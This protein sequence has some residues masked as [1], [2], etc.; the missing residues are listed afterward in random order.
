MPVFI[1]EADRLC[2][3]DLNQFASTNS[4]CCAAHFGL[5]E[6][7]SAINPQTNREN[8]LSRNQSRCELL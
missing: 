5:A 4:P 1:R 3:L 6:G 8:T 7:I 2:R